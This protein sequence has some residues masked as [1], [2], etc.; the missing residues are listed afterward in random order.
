MRFSILHGPDAAGDRAHHN[1][2]LQDARGHGLR[3]LRPFPEKTAANGT[4]TTHL[5]S[6][7]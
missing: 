6:G 1:R 4:G 2:Q 5:V 7:A 3:G